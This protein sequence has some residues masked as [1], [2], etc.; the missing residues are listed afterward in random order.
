MENNRILSPNCIPYVMTK[1]ESINIDTI[2]DVS[3]AES[4]LQSKI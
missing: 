1:D 4:K 2:D 3:L